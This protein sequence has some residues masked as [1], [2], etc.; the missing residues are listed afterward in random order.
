MNIGG[1]DSSGHIGDGYSMRVNPSM[2]IWWNINTDDLGEIIYLNENITIR[3]NDDSFGKY[4]VILDTGTDFN[5]FPTQ[6]Y[7]SFTS[8]VVKRCA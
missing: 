3:Q 2:N 1:V 4:G 6:I 7:N 5:I 8:M